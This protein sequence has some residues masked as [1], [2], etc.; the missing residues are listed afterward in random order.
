MKVE[1]SSSGAQGNAI[2][3]QEQTE[4]TLA[5]LLYYASIV[6]SPVDLG[7]WASLVGRLQGRDKTMNA[8]LSFSRHKRI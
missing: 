5:R 1:N 7:V 2:S 3:I 8:Q 4:I 6:N